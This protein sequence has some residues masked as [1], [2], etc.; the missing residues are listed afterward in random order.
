MHSSK[1]IVYLLYNTKNNGGNRVIFE[2]V[3]RLR[4]QGYNV[5]T[6]AL[7]PKNPSWF[8]E[9]IQIGNLSNLFFEQNINILVATFWPT[10]YFSL[11]KKANKKFYFIQNWEE[12]FY[13]S[14]LLKFLVKRSLNFRIEKITISKFLKNR[15][16]KIYGKQS[17]FLIK[18][19]GLDYSIFKFKNLKKNSSKVKIISV[20]SSYSQYKGLDLLELTLKKIKKKHPSF[21]FTLVSTEQKSYSSYFDVFVSNPSRLELAK[22]YQ[23]SNILLSTSRIEGF[24]IP[25]IEA[26][27]CG[28]LLITTNNGGIS[29][30]AIDNKNAIIINKLNILWSEDIIYK[31]IKDKKKYNEL[32][33]EGIKTSRKYSWKTVINHLKKIYD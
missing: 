27:A 14:K 6:F 4:N 25:G 31:I 7:F 11:L 15:I 17:I 30:Y 3:S 2:H 22:L 32:I 26:M 23:K 1:K 13:K 12:D 24:Y 20:V 29:E 33:L 10:A 9:K 8:S 19:S 18:D 5:K 28:C 21:E 16:L